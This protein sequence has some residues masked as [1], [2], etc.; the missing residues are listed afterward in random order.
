LKRSF[1]ALYKKKKQQNK[2]LRDAERERILKSLDLDEK[3]PS[4]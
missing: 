2:I 4:G 1:L 3:T